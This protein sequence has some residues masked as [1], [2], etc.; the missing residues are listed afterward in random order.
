MTRYLRERTLFPPLI[1]EAPADQLGLAVVIPAQDEPELVKSLESLAHCQDPDDSV[2]VI[3]VVN[4]SEAD[5]EECVTE[6]R[7]I[8]SRGA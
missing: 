4:T 1:D 8:C 2:E 6:N 5:S 3:V 7:R